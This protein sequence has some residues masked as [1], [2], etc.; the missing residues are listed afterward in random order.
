M[1]NTILVGAQWGDE[2]KGKIIDVL[3]E[4]ADIV[5]RTQGGNNAGHTVFL[6]EKKYVLHLIPSG[7]LRPKKT[8]VIGN[9]VV[10]DPVNLVGEIDG[11]LRAGIAV[12]DNLL[13]S[14]TAHLVFPYHRELDEQREILKGKNKIGTTKRG[15]GPAYGDKAARTGVRMIDLVNA[16]RFEE[17]LR[18]RI[19]ENNEVLKA[20]G[21]K[22]LS[23]A[24][25]HAAYRAA[26]D[27]LKPFVTNTVVYLHKATQRKAE[28]L[29]EGAQGTFLDIDHGTYPFVTSSNTTAG[30]ACTGSGVAPNRMTRVVG[31]MKAYTTR[32]GEGP[33]PTEN[34]EISDLLHGMGR[35][36]GATTGRARRCGWFDSVATRHATMVN[37]IDELA[38]TNLDG[39]DTVEVIKACIGY[40]IGTSR[41]DYIP[42]DIAAL[43]KCEPIYAEFP[44]WKIPTDKCKTW[45]D[46][47][48]KARTYLK[49]IAELTGAK[50]FIASVGPARAQTIFV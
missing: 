42:N 25:V 21:A 31:V 37:G 47:P 50:L 6:G 48:I 39:L 16:D 46:L 33:L 24:K 41:I 44:G 20:F 22:P 35:E 4:K 45:K 34:A 15:I 13:I 5:V 1:A 12:K 29:F 30:G 7:I 40:R 18:T 3:T 27:R 9:G 26:G 17:I 2:G 23:F 14:E 49:A 43:A 38:V 19:K 32:V 10:I 36:F 11:L 8:C 28:I